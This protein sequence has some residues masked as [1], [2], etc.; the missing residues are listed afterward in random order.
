MVVDDDQLV[1]A[2]VRIR[3]A[4]DGAA[5]SLSVVTDL[6]I[7]AVYNS[8]TSILRL[9][10]EGSAESYSQVLRSLKYS[11]SSQNPSVEDRMIEVIVTDGLS[12]SSVATA[13]VTVEVWIRP[14]DSVAGT[15][16]TRWT[17]RSNLSAPKA[18]LPLIDTMTSL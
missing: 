8:S 7:Q 1:S 18:P 16:W 15:R 12:N 13:T 9:S 4:V 5:E 6:G 10:G 11:N 3:N 17:P 14:W 2:T